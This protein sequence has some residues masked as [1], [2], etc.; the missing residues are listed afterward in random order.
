MTPGPVLTFVERA[1]GRGEHPAVDGPDGLWSYR[2]LLS[3]SA[4]LAHRL[5]DGRENLAGDRVA[6]LVDPGGRNVAALWG[7]WRAGGLAVPLAVSHPAAELRHVLED[8]GASQVVV[9]AGYR[10]RVEEGAADGIRIVEL[11]PRMPPPSTPFPDEPP[12][13]P[14]S[15]DR[16]ALMIYTSGTTGRPKGAVHTHRSLDAQVESL[17]RAWGWSPD[18]RI[19]LV[20]PLH[21]VHGLVNVL[22][23]ALW[24]GARCDVLPR[25]D[26]EATWDRIAGG[27]LT[28]FMAVP[29]IYARLI[30][31]WDEATPE[32][33]EELS[34]A[35]R[36]LRLMVSGSAALP[37]PTLERWLAISGH[38]LLE[39]YGM[40][41]IGMALSN[42]LVG[43]RR[44][45]LVGFPLPG[46]EVR[47]VDEE[48]APVLPGTPGEIEVRGE[49]LFLE[50]WDR[51]EE[52]RSA[53]H[54]GWFRTGDVAL[55]EE[56][57]YRILGRRSVDILK[58]GGYKISALEIE[59]VLRDH[60]AV[61]DCAVVGIP[62]PTWGERVA[63]AVVPRPGCTLDPEALRNWAAQRLAPYKVPWR[64]LVVDELPR[65]AMGKV[66]KP[67]VRTLLET[68][69]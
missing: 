42:P 14:V 12:L 40:T 36:G 27:G 24:N 17:T 34:R 67:A 68:M 23:C 47:L 29:T 44:P 45:G 31:A 66:T 39:R 63:A 3:A 60:S 4:T 30:A 9:E 6:F 20:L 33:R 57:G 58:S 69:R 16:R 8:S 51:P 61:E 19:L 55:L 22:C 38:V 13:P 5:L 49:T 28:L 48:G 52:T 2:A 65:N 21:H 46:V 26:A 59:A 53:F 43:D 32:R 41:E 18:D 56:D 25:F 10:E 64:V 1:R 62:D 54:D 7:I 50:Y 15:G 35:C 11:P 37:V